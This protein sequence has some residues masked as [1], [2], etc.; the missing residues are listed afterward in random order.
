MDGLSHN[1]VRGAGGLLVQHGVRSQTD[2]LLFKQRRRKPFVVRLDWSIVSFFILF[3][4]NV[5]QMQIILSFFLD[6]HRGMIF[7]MYI[8]VFVSF[9][10]LLCD[11]NIAVGSVSCSL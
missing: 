4:S 6:G 7:F 8:Q 2:V 1:E 10:R 11:E 3:V 9:Q 5:T